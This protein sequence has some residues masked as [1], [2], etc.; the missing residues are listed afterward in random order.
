MK[1]RKSSIFGHVYV[2]FD[3][4]TN[5]KKYEYSPLYEITIIV[6]TNADVTIIIYTN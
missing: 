4:T 5:C 6:I 1:F 3:S 2:D